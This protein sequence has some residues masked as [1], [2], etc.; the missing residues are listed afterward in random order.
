MGS[1]PKTKFSTVDEYIAALP[2]KVRDKVETLRKT[3]KLTAP[4]A[5]EAISYNMPAFRLH[6]ILVYYAAHKEHIGFYPADAKVIRLFQTDLAGFETSKGTI[7]FPMEK[8]IPV[9][10][11]EKIVLYRVRENLVKAGI[12]GNEQKKPSSSS[13]KK[14]Y[15]Q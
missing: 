1:P 15:R 4:N 8:A 7:R 9:K 12:N 6:R 13:D 14:H 10:L 11:V 3:I 2:E 5:V